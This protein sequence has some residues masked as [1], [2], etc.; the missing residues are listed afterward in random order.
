[1]STGGPRGE[2][3]ET[4]SKK[5]KIEKDKFNHFEKVQYTEKQK[6]RALIEMK[7]S[8]NGDQVSFAEVW[9]LLFERE[10]VVVSF[11]LQHI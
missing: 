10:D 6:E 2:K 11:R 5:R 3:A 1:M 4:V 7:N 9:P 8:A